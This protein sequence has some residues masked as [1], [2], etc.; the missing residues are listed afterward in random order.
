[1][2]LNLFISILGTIISVLALLETIAKKV[3]NITDSVSNSAEN[4]DN[5]T[6]SIYNN[7]E[8]INNSINYLIK[9]IH[10]LPAQRKEE[11]TTRKINKSLNNGSEKDKSKQLELENIGIPRILIEE[12]KQVDNYSIEQQVFDNIKEGN[13]CYVI[14]GSCLKKSQL[15]NEIKI[16]ESLDVSNIKVCILNVCDIAKECQKSYILPQQFQFWYEKV[17]N[18]INEELNLQYIYFSS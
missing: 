6:Q 17:I 15:L 8:R 14:C 9:N 13:L 2:E 11:E 10:A 1:M 4:L 12:I 7:A 18:I 16:E 3:E 5:T